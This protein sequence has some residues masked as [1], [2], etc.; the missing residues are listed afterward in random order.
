MVILYSELKKWTLGE[1][2][3][4]GLS[5]MHSVFPEDPLSIFHWKNDDCWMIF[6]LWAKNFRTLPKTYGRVSEASIYVSRESVWDKK[7]KK[8][9]FSVIL[10]FERKFLIIARKCLSMCAKTAC[11]VSSETFWGNE[12]C[13]KKWFLT[14]FRAF[15]WKFWNV[16]KN[17]TAGFPKLQTNCP[18]KFFAKIFFK[19]SW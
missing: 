19:K 18:G 14:T 1:T 11:C 4:H 3:W 2:F 17:I 6:V 8:Y 7:L 9:D 10:Y 16:D 13:W 15:S 5:K 12:G